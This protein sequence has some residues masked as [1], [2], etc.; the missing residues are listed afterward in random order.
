[1]AETR[2]FIS[3]GLSKTF[4]RPFFGSAGLENHAK[5]GCD[6]THTTS[7]VNLE[8]GTKSFYNVFQVNLDPT[9]L[10]VE[11]KSKQW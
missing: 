8:D 11:A 9:V 7:M 1:V 6:S 3:A 4:L 5:K 10:V 2:Q